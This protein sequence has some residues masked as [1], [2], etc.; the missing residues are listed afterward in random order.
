MKKKL[1]VVGMILIG[2]LGVNGCMKEEMNADEKMLEH[3]H[4]KYG[5]EF[6]I[7]NTIGKNQDCSYDVWY[8]NAKGDDPITDKIEVHLYSKG[9]YGDEYYT[10]LAREEIERRAMEAILEVTEEGKVFL[11]NFSFAPEEFV[12]LDQLDEFL[13]TEEGQVAFGLIIF[14]K[15]REKEGILN[16]EVINEFEKVLKDAGVGRASIRIFFVKNDDVFQQINRGSYY[17]MI[18]WRD[19]KKIYTVDYSGSLKRGF[20]TY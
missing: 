8:C 9:E 10:R 17:D 6:E 4:E 11:S 14:M 15:D 5:V 1:L 12:E 3:M 19:E 13:Q 16:Q 7:Q 2:M 20:R 18:F